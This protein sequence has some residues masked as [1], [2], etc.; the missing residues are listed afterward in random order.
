MTSPLIRLWAMNGR[1]RGLWL[2][3]C[4]VM[5]WRLALL[6]FTA[7]PVPANDAFLFDGAM[8]N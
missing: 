6:L 4:L 3:L 5:A 8:V 2:A 1:S 7:Q